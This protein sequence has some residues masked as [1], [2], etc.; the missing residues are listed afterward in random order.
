MSLNL[1]TVQVGCC[2]IFLFC[3]SDTQNSFKS[4]EAC[5]RYQDSGENGSIKNAKV[6]IIAT[7]FYRIIWLTI[8]F[9]SASSPCEQNILKRVFF[10]PWISTIQFQGILLN[11]TRQDE[12]HIANDLQTVETI[13]FPMSEHFQST[14]KLNSSAS[15]NKIK[16]CSKVRHPAPE[17]CL[18]QLTGHWGFS[19]VSFWQMIHLNQSHDWG[20]LF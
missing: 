17:S 9:I 3:P 5:S 7:I 12:C 1:Q 11:A 6:R 18:F 10:L 16:S 20:S 2:K 14:A 8:I 4:K 15:E 13:I 19:V